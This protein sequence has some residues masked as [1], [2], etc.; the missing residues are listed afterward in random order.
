M[1]PT[2]PNSV[3]KLPPFTNTLTKHKLEAETMSKLNAD[4]DYDICYPGRPIPH[5][6]D[7]RSHQYCGGRIPMDK[8]CI[9]CNKSNVLTMQLLKA[10]QAPEKPGFDSFEINPS[11]IIA[12]EESQDY[13]SFDKDNTFSVTPTL[14]LDDEDI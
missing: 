3:P 5:R 8:P 9:T 4:G 6:I 1:E 7:S 10:D 13:R 12:Q 2:V 14:L 11:N